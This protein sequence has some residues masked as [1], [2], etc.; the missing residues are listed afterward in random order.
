MLDLLLRFEEDFMS[1]SKQKTYLRLC[2]RCRAPLQPVAT[3][4]YSC[5][6]QLGPVQPNSTI[7]PARSPLS[8][9][10]RKGP[11]GTEKNRA[12]FYY[13][14][15]V[16]SVI[17]LITFVAIHASG[18]SPSTLFS[19]AA[20]P[21]SIIKYP[22]PP[23]TPIFSDNFLSDT[24][25]WNLQSSPGNYAVTTGNGAL[26]LQVNKNKL[27]WELLPGERSYSNFTLTVNAVLSKGDQNNGYGVYIRGASNSETDL[28]TYYRFEL[29]GDGSYAIFKGTIDASG[30]SGDTKMVDYTLSSA[31]QKQGKVNQIM[32]IAKGAALSFIV[33]GQLLQTIT[34][35]N[36]SSGSVALFVSNL[37]QAK[38]GATVQFSRLA[39]YAAHA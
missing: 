19:K 21:T 13:F 10:N 34:D 16:I 33:N 18:I 15:S 4:C 1:V 8:Y 30:R 2:P 20:A 37:P 6:Y 5:G 26:T 3:T 39:I 27:L 23:G 25:G 17:I 22:T 32:I 35:N 29:Y 24:Y 9:R 11:S 12:A 36:Y 14:I 38:P 7:Q 28:A 31:I